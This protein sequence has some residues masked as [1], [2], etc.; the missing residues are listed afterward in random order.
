MN[1]LLLP[2]SISNGVHSVVKRKHLLIS[3][4]IF[5][6]IFSYYC[7][8]FVIYYFFSPTMSSPDNPNT[9]KTLP[10]V[11]KTSTSTESKERE[12]TSYENKPEYL[13]L[14]QKTKFLSRGFTA[15]PSDWFSFLGFNDSEICPTF[16]IVEAVFNSTP[17]KKSIRAPVTTYVRAHCTF[18]FFYNTCFLLLINEL[19]NLIC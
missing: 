10:P 1:F 12:F 4:P 16:F 9:P 19:S 15:L 18:Y 5:Y 8:I 14:L 3:C 6:F 7:I 11:P 17:S 13:S 2:Q